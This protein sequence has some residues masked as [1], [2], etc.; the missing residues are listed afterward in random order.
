MSGVPSF[1]LLSRRQWGYTS[2]AS[3]ALGGLVAFFSW[4]I[5]PWIAVS[6]V[7]ATVTAFHM[8]YAGHSI[9]ALPHIAILVAALQYVFA[10]WLS[11]HWPHPD[12]TY[13]IGPRLP[14]YLAFAGPAVCFT[15][16]GWMLAILKLPARRADVGA[17]SRRLLSEL[18]ILILLGVLG[19]ILGRVVEVQNVAFVF[20][21]IG[22]L[23]F[24]GIFGRMLLKGEG[25][26]W[27]LAAILGAEVLIAVG[28]TMFHTLILWIFWVFV[29][30]LYSFRPRPKVVLLA[31]A[32]ALVLLPALQGAKWH[33]REAPMEDPV[34]EAEMTGVG[35][36]TLRR[37][38][39]WIGYFPEAIL[40]TITLRLDPDFIAAM[41][42]RYNQGWIVDRVMLHVPDSEPHAYGE[43]I[44]DA[45]AAALLPRVIAP[46]KAVAGGRENMLRFAGMELNETTAMNL[47]Y[48][49]EMYAN[50]GVVGGPIACGAYA[51]AFG[52]I[53]RF[54]AKRALL[55]PLW[56]ALVPYL[57]FSVLK[58]E[59]DLAN[60]LNYTVKSAVVVAVICLCFPQI[61]DAL[62]GRSQ[63]PRRASSRPLSVDDATRPLVGTAE[64]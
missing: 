3:C 1:L 51:F 52:L 2:A 28:S 9:L 43:T 14:V 34:M 22:N 48:A 59:D 53:F 26:R 55:S 8:S 24:V 4:D 54:I 36:T 27:R 58:A 20:V 18:D 60:A 21:L 39:A 16:A 46:N 10:A 45:A 17:T 49:G 57:F 35:E 47:G 50:F 30:W 23:R 42:V 38:I 33:L 64:L 40:E 15:A 41:A 12:P 5:S 7:V 61:R 13:D 6:T 11:F 62:F 37:A 31:V 32:V 19:V 25:W 56:W 44:K 63:P 29:I